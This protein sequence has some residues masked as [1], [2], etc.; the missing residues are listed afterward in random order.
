MAIKIPAA[1]N[2]AVHRA[3]TRAH[4]WSGQN[5]ID[6]VRTR[7]TQGPAHARVIADPL[8]TF[9]NAL[10]V[11]PAQGRGRC[12]HCA[13][14][15]DDVNFSAEEVFFA[16]AAFGHVDTPGF[17][18]HYLPALLALAPFL[19]CGRDD[20]DGF[21]LMRRGM[22]QWEHRK[23]PPPLLAFQPRLEPYGTTG[24]QVAIPHAYLSAIAGTMYGRLNPNG[25]IRSGATHGLTESRLPIT[26]LGRRTRI[27]TT[28]GD[29][30]LLAPN[31]SSTIALR[32]NDRAGLFD[33]IT[34]YLL[35]ITRSRDGTTATLTFEHT[36]SSPLAL[37]DPLA[38]QEQSAM[39]ALGFLDTCATDYP[40]PDVDWLLP[41]PHT[42]GAYSVFA[43][44]RVGVAPLASAVFRTI[45]ASAATPGFTQLSGW[46]QVGDAALWNNV[47][48]QPFLDCFATRGLDMQSPLLDLAFRF[49]DAFGARGHG[50]VEIESAGS[51]PCP[52]RFPT[53]NGRRWFC[54][55]GDRMHTTHVAKLRGPLPD[56]TTLATYRWKNDAFGVSYHTPDILA[57]WMLFA[58]DGTELYRM[59]MSNDGSTAVMAY[60][61]TELRALLATV[62]AQYP[63]EIGDFFNIVRWNLDPAN[64]PARP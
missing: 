57:C 14:L 32:A 12:D 20:D 53:I 35:G 64:A 45:S 28:V 55:T 3:I 43:E 50:G 19:Y 25:P 52:A 18:T 26:P 15:Q 31:A 11:V 61:K 40:L 38:A 2:A 63:T 30:L 42:P 17:H 41:H 48:L 37:A 47:S 60:R 22:S 54:T 16:L 27:I 56:N 34:A 13:A 44:R 7:L 33:A 21:A 58:P 62:P 46:T 10:E 9:A 59:A 5:A 23:N 24:M 6:P 51:D 49:G 39:L 1:A 4:Q 29:A 8:A 36:P